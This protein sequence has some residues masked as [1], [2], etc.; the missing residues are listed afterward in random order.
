MPSLTAWEFY[1]GRG[2][3]NIKQQS[4]LRRHW[5]VLA[6]LLR[7]ETTESIPE[8]AIYMA[9]DILGE[10]TNTAYASAQAWL[11]KEEQKVKMAEHVPDNGEQK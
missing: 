7:T 10:S 8:D 6:Q 3:A 1:R 2:Q 4:R 9:T 5:L 11:A